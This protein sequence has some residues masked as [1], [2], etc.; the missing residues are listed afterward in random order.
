MP[1]PSNASAHDSGTRM[2]G[3]IVIDY[4]PEWPSAIREMTQWV[5]SGKIKSKNFIV[6][7]GL[8]VAQQALQDLFAGVNTGE[9]LVGK[10]KSTGKTTGVVAN[11][12][13]GKMILE[14]HNPG[15]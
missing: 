3:F 14:V 13:V 8:K 2:E 10:V 6:K 9:C 5:A 7:G 15:E 12:V 1:M 4:M 11:T